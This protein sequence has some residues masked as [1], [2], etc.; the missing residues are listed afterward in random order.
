MTIVMTSLHNFISQHGVEQ[1]DPEATFLLFLAVQADIKLLIHL[2][3]I[4]RDHQ[5]ALSPAAWR[6]RDMV[7]ITIAHLA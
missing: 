7:S 3:I 1:L 4:S 6:E 5:E 2:L